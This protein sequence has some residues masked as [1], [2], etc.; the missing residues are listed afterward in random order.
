ME[1]HY[2]KSNDVFYITHDTSGLI[3]IPLL[4]VDIPKIS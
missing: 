3:M 1:L 2:N 4:D